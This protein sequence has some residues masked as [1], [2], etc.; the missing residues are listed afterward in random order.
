M[1]VD[2]LAQVFSIGAQICYNMNIFHKWSMIHSMHFG[3]VFW[4][5]LDGELMSAPWLKSGEV[6]DGTYGTE[7]QS[8]YVSE[9]C[10]LE[11][12]NL[13][14]LLDIHKD[15]ILEQYCSESSQR[16]DVLSA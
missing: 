2:K 16:T 9:W 6:L 8:D 11:G 5:N 7:D 15:L 13:E 3:R 12:L 1:Q 10:D 14:R 4:L